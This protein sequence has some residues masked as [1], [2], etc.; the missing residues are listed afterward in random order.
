M[1][2]DLMGYEENSLEIDEPQATPE[3]ASEIIRLILRKL[4][5]VKSWDHRAQVKKNELNIDMLLDDSRDDFLPELLPFKY[6]PYFLEAPESMQKT[7][8]SCGWLA[9]NEKTVNIEA[10]IVNPA[11]MHII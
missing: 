9:Y 2:P 4:N 3:E 10:K 11:C 5:R 6:H 1:I 8:L 7:I